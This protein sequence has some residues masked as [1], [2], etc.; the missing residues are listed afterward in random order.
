MTGERPVF[1]L[2][3]GARTGSTLVQRLLISTR[4]VLVWGEHGGH[5]VHHLIRLSIELAHWKSEAQADRQR[6]AFEAQGHAAW[7]PN[8][9]PAHAGLMRGAAALLREH[10]G[11]SARE[12]GYPRWGFKEI[13]YGRRAVTFLRTLYPD[14]AL[15]LVVRDPVRALASHLATPWARSG[16]DLDAEAFVQRWAGLSGQLAEAR[17]EHAGALLLR[18]EDLVATP[19]ASVDALSSATGIARDR[20]DRAV[21]GDIRRGSTESPAALGE[22]ELALL[23]RPAVR[24]V[25]DRFGYSLP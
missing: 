17:D 15:V 23:D 14:C 8:M 19:D 5:Y 21:F 4:E 7:I 20:F 13:R 12:M 2:C 25:M 18:Y 22:R 11:Q 9:N 1:V 3:G 6:R 24:A 10:L 16:R